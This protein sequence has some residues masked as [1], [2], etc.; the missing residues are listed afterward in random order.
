[1]NFGSTFT[2]I[3]TENTLNQSKTPLATALFEESKMQR[4]A[5]DVPGHKGNLKELGDYFGEQALMLDKNSRVSIDNI[6]QPT[7]VILQAERLA[8]QAFKAKHA[9]FMVG[10]TTSSVQAMIM[11]AIL[12]GEKI[13][14]P[15]N[16]HASVINGVILSGGVPVYVN[17]GVHEEFGIPLGMHLNDVKE[18]ILLNPDAKAI[19]VNNPTY[20]GVC[21]DLKGIVEFSHRYGL[22]VLADEAHGTHFYFGD[23]LPLS[24]MAAGADMAAVSMHKT[25]GSLTQSSLL[26]IGDGIDEQYVRQIINLSMTT[27]ASYLLLASIDIARKKLATDG[28]KIINSLKALSQK[29]V[30]RINEGKVFRAFEREK[31]VKAYGVYDFDPIKISINT[32]KIGLA[33]IE[34]YNI[35]LNEYNVQ[36]EFGDISNVLALPALGDDEQNFERLVFAV[37]DIAKKYSGNNTPKYRYEYIQPVVKLAPRTAFYFPKERV[38]LSEAEGRI[39]GEFVACY[40][41]GIPLLAPGEL[42]TKEIIEHVEYS[43]SKGCKIIGGTGNKIE[44]IQVVK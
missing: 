7:G 4:V 41:P 19:L 27:S 43:Q 10:G 29:T 17:P 37:N 38:N 26:L 5:F 34:V 31:M 2:P 39:S 36:M 33:G 24:A 42:I 12:P 11:S 22:K 20:Y 44:K 25:G 1:M 8:A 14:L 13:I 15:R 3:K 30:K 28:K 9:F 40:P 21:S 16:V 18:A 23:E 32:E 35:L 6:C